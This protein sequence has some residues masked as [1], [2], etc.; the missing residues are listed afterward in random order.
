MVLQI[1]IK[2]EAAKQRLRPYGRNLIL[3]IQKKFH[4]I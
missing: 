1:K 2:K 3:E 4:R